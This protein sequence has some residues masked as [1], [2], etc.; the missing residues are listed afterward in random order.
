MTLLFIRGTPLVSLILTLFAQL[1]F[2][3]MSSDPTAS[4]HFLLEVI[5]DQGKA[6][7]LCWVSVR[8]AL[9]WRRRMR[10]STPEERRSTHSWQIFTPKKHIYPMPPL[11]FVTCLPPHPLAFHQDIRSVRR[12][13]RLLLVSKAQ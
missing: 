4:R 7:K 10:A 1:P 5:F 6:V 9:S 13:L 8:L 12:K 11:Q 3:S 2:E